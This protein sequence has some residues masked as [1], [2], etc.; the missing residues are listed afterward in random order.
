MYNLLYCFFLYMDEYIRQKGIWRISQ[1][2]SRCSE[3][4]VAMPCSTI[5]SDS[6]IVQNKV[7]TNKEDPWCTI[8]HVHCF[9]L[10]LNGKHDNV[11]I[12]G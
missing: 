3:C 9:L 10:F 5:L 7:Y 1:D 2:P 6:F 11:H 8:H 4:L 12:Y